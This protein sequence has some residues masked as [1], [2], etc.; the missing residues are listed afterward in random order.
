M[1]NKTRIVFFVD[2]LERHFDGVSNTMHQLAHRI[3]RDEVEAIF[4]TTYPPSQDD[5][6]FPVYQ[7]PYISWILYKDY[8]IGQPGRMK[9]LEQLL[10]DF[11]PQLLHFTSPT[12]MGKF[13]IK[14]AER[15]NLPVTTTYH[16]HFHS[17]MEYYF[18]FFRPLEKLM[19]NVALRLSRW[20]Y[21]RVNTTFVPSEPM[22]QFLLDL[23]VE[24][25]KIEYFRRGINAQHFDPSYR[26]AELRASYGLKDKKIVL[27]VSRLVKEKELDTLIR[28][29][30]LFQERRSDVTFMITGDGPF[31]RYM[32]KRMPD[33]IFTGKQTKEELAR[34]Y[35]TADVF[36]FPSTTETFG[37]VVLEAMASGIPVVA[38]AAGGPKGIVT[39]SEAGYVVEP[40]NEEGFY[41]KISEII[42]DPELHEKF[43]K[44]AVQ[45]AQNQ[46]WDVLCA[47]MV[48]KLKEVAGSKV[49]SEE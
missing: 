48:S 10:A 9:E 2:I 46:N 19:G 22:R 14:Y 43:A 44:N 45:Y 30:R 11:K 39:R 3:P 40:K 35:A 28:T 36:I 6:P 5:F 29:N 17:Y 38:A 12:L 27:F 13:A 24:G 47:G 41:Q 16:T 26:S 23:G 49:M 1:T 7:C 42:D 25:S 4:I 8:R 21:T 18:G 20:Y 33:A 32:E 15:H 31:K 34:L 37:N